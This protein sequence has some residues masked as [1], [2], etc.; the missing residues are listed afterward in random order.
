MSGFEIVGVVLGAFPI[1]LEALKQYEVVKTQ[2]RRWREIQ[3]EYT[4][5][6][7]NLA[8]QQLLFEDNI[9]DLFSTLGADEEI[10]EDFISSCR[11]GTI[12]DNLLENVLEH[13][14]NE[15]YMHCI[16]AMKRTMEALDHELGAETEYVQKKLGSEVRL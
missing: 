10:V 2:V 13:E 15:L 6:E 7:T 9:Q 16:R 3:E 11:Q 1:V 4:E 8:F 14:Y 12:Q 5:C